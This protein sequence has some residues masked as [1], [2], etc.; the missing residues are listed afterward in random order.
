M[1][2]YD[3]M[4]VVYHAAMLMPSTESDP[5]FN[6]RNIGNDYVA[7]VY[8]DSGDTYPMGTVKG[9]FFYAHIIGNFYLGLAYIY[10]F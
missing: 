5:Q 2:Q 3:V 9:H 8:N 1:W 7:I 6:K 10:P 4:Q